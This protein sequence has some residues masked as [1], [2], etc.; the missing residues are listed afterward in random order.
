VL[1]VAALAVIG[2]AAGAQD[3]AEATF[4]GG[5]FWCMEKPFDDLEGVLSTTS[6]YSGGHVANPSYTQ[7]TAGGT[8]HLEVVQVIYDPEMVTFEE[9]LYVFW[10]NVDPTD[11][12]GQFCDRGDSYRPAIFVSS[13]AERG[14][15]ERSAERV[16][17]ELGRRVQV[18]VLVF[19][20]FYPAEDYHQDYYIRNP[21]RYAWYR[22]G[23]GRDRRLQ[24][25]WGDEAG[26]ENA[27]M[28]L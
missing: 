28:W 10:R 22:S 27:G 5:C 16:R 6:G 4:A 3:L 21:L 13:E 20:V 1:I 23:C 26:G 25:I 18:D 11:G 15:A 19:E 24:E 9:L 17:R 12:G 14:L 8:G 2:A 7:V